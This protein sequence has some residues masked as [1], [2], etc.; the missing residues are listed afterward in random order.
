[1]RQLS[2]SDITGLDYRNFIFS[3]KLKARWTCKDCKWRC[4]VEEK[5]EIIV[6][7]KDSD[8]NNN[9][10]DNLVVLCCD[11]HDIRHGW[12]IAPKRA[13]VIKLRKIDTERR[14]NRPRRQYSE[15][16]WPI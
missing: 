11:C 3:I 1:M 9:S 16:G 5:G 13:K 6:H 4:P 8:P 2:D 10:V 15:N 7:H 14:L 12:G